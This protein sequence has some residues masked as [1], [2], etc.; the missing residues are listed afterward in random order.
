MRR[1]HKLFVSFSCPVFFWKSGRRVRTVRERPVERGRRRT[2]GGDAF[3]PV[4]LGTGHGAGRTCRR[5]PTVV[6]E[7]TTEESRRRATLAFALLRLRSVHS[8][9]SSDLLGTGKR[10]WTPYSFVKYSVNLATG[11]SKNVLSL[12]GNTGRTLRPRPDPKMSQNLETGP[13]QTE[14]TSN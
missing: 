10:V 7:W 5:R 13:C 11:Y 14:N 9:S 1:G 12:F 6:V 2:R 8:P 4:C 3:W